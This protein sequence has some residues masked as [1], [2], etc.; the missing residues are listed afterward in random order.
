MGGSFVTLHPSVAVPKAPLLP[1]RK[2]PHCGVYMHA[3]HRVAFRHTW[4]LRHSSFQQVKPDAVTDVYFELHS[5]RN[6]A[7]ETTTMAAK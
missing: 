1:E 4:M 5:R 7:S 3:C 2:W 6:L